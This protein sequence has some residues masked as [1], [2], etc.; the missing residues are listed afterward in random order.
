MGRATAY[1]QARAHD[2]RSGL[3]KACPAFRLVYQSRMRARSD[4]PYTKITVE[5]LPPPYYP[6]DPVRACA[7]AHTHTRRAAGR[8][9][10]RDDLPPCRQPSPVL[11]PS[12]RCALACFPS[13]AE[14]DLVSPAYRRPQIPTSS[15]WLLRLLLRLQPTTRQRQ[16]RGRR[17]RSPTLNPPRRIAS[18]VAPRLSYEPPCPA[19]PRAPRLLCSR[20]S[21]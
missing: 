8:P 9:G 19:L 15:R 3:G 14:R 2:L 11:T 18:P 17:L 13:V 7:R 16:R 12:G 21:H 10:R 4:H 20:L 1:R 5:K 6:Y